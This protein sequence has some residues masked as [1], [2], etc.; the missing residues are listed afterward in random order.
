MGLV[1]LMTEPEYRQVEAVSYSVLSGVSKTP[2]SLLNTKKLESPSLT[3]G[4]AVDTLAFDGE[5]VFKSKFC[6][7]SVESPTPMVESIVKEVMLIAK[8]QGEEY[9]AKLDDYDEL[10][11]TIAATRGYGKGWNKGTALRKIKDEG[12]RDLYD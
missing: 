10:I 6:I 7:N 3:Y 12:G 2:A 9:A 5:E 1:K 8:E 4:S 11:D